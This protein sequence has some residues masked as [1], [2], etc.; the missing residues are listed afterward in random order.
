M[1]EKTWISDYLTVLRD[2]KLRVTYQPTD[3]KQLLRVFFR[4]ADE[5]V[6]DELCEA[7]HP[8]PP[9]AEIILREQTGTRLNGIPVRIRRGLDEGAAAFEE[10]LQHMEDNPLLVPTYIRVSGTSER[11]GFNF[12][13]RP[14]EIELR[15]R[16]KIS[17]N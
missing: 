14:K 8:L 17:L 7:Y 11:S 3:M 2:T 5:G 12:Q 4:D 6:F 10:A 15:I 13:A 16:R 1:I 9:T